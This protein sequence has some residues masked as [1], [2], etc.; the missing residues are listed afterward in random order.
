[1]ALK[2]CREPAI[3]GPIDIAI[4]FWL[5]D[6]SNGIEEGADGTAIM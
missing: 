2:L 5:L 1:M 6:V 4:Y 3:W